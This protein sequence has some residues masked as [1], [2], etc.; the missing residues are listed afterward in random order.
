MA[1]QLIEAANLLS[2][3]VSTELHAKIMRGVLRQNHKNGGTVAAGMNIHRA[4]LRLSPALAAAIVL[5]SVVG[6][7]LYIS[8][9][10]KPERVSPELGLSIT[11][12]IGGGEFATIVE[13]ALQWPIEEE[14]R[15]LS[16][17]GKAAAEFLLACVPLDI[18]R[19]ADND[20]GLD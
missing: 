2:P 1:D 19:F 6:L 11:D 13:E 20:T 7:Y 4:W 5:L 8:S 18:N 17:D 14:I 16:Q 10:Q 9:V 12:P 3:Q 15:L